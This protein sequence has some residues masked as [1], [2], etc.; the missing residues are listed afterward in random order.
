M[1]LYAIPGGD[2][3][4]TE[5][6]YNAKMKARGLDPKT[7][8]RRKVDVPTNKAGLLEFLTFHTVDPIGGGG[9]SILKA[10]GV[11]PS[12]PVIDIDALQRAHNP[13]APDLPPAP[14][15]ED[16]SSATRTLSAMESP[17]VDIDSIVETICNSTGHTLKRFASAVAT[18]FAALA[19]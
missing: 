4:G 3:A 15:A 14:P 7:A 5:K 19:A 11:G 9:T 2:W 13:N 10:P 8:T 17:G 16:V 12:A 1:E 18:A 6:D